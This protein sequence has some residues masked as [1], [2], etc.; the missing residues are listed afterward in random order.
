M[1]LCKYPVLTETECSWNTQAS[2][3]KGGGGDWPW[4]VCPAAPSWSPPT[5]MCP[6]AWPGTRL[7]TTHCRSL[8]R[9]CSSPPEV[10]RAPGLKWPA[11]S[12][13]CRHLYLKPAAHA[14][15]VSLPF[16][17]HSASIFTSCSQPT[18]SL[19]HCC[20]YLDPA[21]Q[22][23]SVLPLFTWMAQKET[24]HKH[25]PSQLQPSQL[26]KI[27]IMDISKVPSLHLKIKYTASF[28]HTLKF[29]WSDLAC[30][31]LK[32]QRWEDQSATSKCHTHSSYGPS[33]FNMVLVIMNESMMTGIQTHAV[34]EAHSENKTVSH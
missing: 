13:P 17:H 27:I 25:T 33:H 14:V 18:C 23:Q 26:T 24:G 29:S 34:T 8:W 5:L 30:W 22:R 21:I 31:L 9:L 1:W 19:C 6:P 32:S 10:G 4:S 28:N 7:Q 3:C 11:P 12:S 16:N 2:N 20:L 15:S